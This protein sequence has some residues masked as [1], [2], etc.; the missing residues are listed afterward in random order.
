MFSCIF[1]LMLH[2]IAERDP[3]SNRQPSLLAAVHISF[4]VAACMNVVVL[5][6]YWSVVY[7][8]EIYKYPRMIEWAFMVYM[9]VVPGVSV[10]MS[11]CMLDVR[12]CARHIWPYVAIGVAFGVFNYWVT[13]KHG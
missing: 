6:V 8:T 5:I 12:L 11:Y 4:E 13:H 7:P 2:L 3:L 9:H 10:A 1:L